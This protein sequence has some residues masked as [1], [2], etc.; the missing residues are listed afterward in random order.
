[1]N[2][3]EYKHTYFTDIYDLLKWLDFWQISKEDIV[4]ITYGPDNL[5]H[6][7]YFDNKKGIKNYKVEKND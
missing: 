3:M 4:A 1:M 2:K 7:I 5:L 6:I